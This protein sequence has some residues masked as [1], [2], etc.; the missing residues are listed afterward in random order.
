MMTTLV[1]ALPDFDK[2]FMAETDACDRGI[3]A[4]L[5]QNGHPIAF[6]SKAL[7]V[8]ISKLSTY[9]KEFLEILMVV[10]KWTCYLQRGSFVIRSD[11]KSLS[12]L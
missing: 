6:Y 3:G 2:E 8:K 9:E 4:L 11:H 7:G 5:S 12:H 10:D 1:L